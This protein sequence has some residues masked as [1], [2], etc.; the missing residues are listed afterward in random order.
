VNRTKNIHFFFYNDISNFN[1]SFLLDMALF[2]NK[3]LSLYR[4]NLDNIAFKSPKFKRVPIFFTNKTKKMKHFD[5]NIAIL[6]G[7]KF[8]FVGRF[9]RKQ[10]S[11]NL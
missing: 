4:F 11:A 10:K 5:D 1:T 6:Y 7:Y 2:K 3:V 8:H 9:T